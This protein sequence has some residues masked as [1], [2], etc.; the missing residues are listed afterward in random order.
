M[1]WIVLDS[2]VQV[3]STWS[4]RRRPTNHLPA[5]FSPF[6]MLPLFN[7]SPIKVSLCCPYKSRAFTFRASVV[8][9]VVS[10]V[11]GQQYSR[12]CTHDFQRYLVNSLA[13]NCSFPSS[14]LC[15]FSSLCIYTYWYLLVYLSTLE[16]NSYTCHHLKCHPLFFCIVSALEE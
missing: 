7:L 11:T 12:G 5:Q 9:L 16:Q 4:N 6:W 2:A 14:S 3:K 10:I 1:F 13:R 8:S 15:V